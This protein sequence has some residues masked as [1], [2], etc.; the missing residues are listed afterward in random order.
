MKDF[1]K[2]Y[3]NP[4]SLG[5]RLSNIKD[6]LNRIFYFEI[7]KGRSR[8]SFYTIKDKLIEESETLDVVK[9]KVE[10]KTTKEKEAER[11][12]IEAKIK[13]MAKGKK[14]KKNKEIK[15]ND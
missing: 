1:S 4:I 8:Q 5:K 7:I 12:D 11:A 9:E 13:S 2:R 6:E 3:K 15:V 10:E 14:T